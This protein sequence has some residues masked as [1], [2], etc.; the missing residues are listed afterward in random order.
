[1]AK[2]AN[3]IHPIEIMLLIIPKNTNIP[4]NGA[5]LFKIGDISF[6]DENG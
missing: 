1:M 2:P 5:S 6:N 4:F 3:V